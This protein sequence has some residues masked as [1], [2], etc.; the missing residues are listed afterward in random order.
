MPE[1]KEQKLLALYTRMR[2]KNLPLKD[3]AQHLVFGEG[4]GDAAVML[5]GEAPGRKEDE[6]G[7]PF[8]G[9]AGRELNQ[10]L[11]E[12]GL[13]RKDVYITSILKYR[14]PDNR[15]PRKPEIESHAPYLIEQIRIIE[16][17]VLVPLGNFA[18]RFLLSHFGGMRPKDI[19]GIS[20][21]RGY[22]YRLSIHGCPYKVLPVY[23][24]AAILYNRKL[25]RIMET[26]F[27][28]IKSRKGN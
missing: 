11:A 13:K 22:F 3:N 5:I 2:G 24:P 18:T 25:T 12:A 21:C 7:R 14:P 27:K 1:T 23:H 8:E 9:S 10:L 28:K 20:A 17:E 4:P 6:L 19:P 16:P 26:D 15:N